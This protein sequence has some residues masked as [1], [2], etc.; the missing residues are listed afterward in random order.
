MHYNNHIL[1]SSYNLSIEELYEDLKYILREGILMKT[2]WLIFLDVLLLF[3]ITFANKNIGKGRR[4]LKVP[5][6]RFKLN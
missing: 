4:A 6:I 3:S 1:L 2:K 5:T